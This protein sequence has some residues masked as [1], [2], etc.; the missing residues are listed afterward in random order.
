[1]NW[2]G[3]CL[4][5]ANGKVLRIN[6]DGTIPADNP[7]VG[8]QVPACDGSPG[9]QP[10]PSNVTGTP[11]TEIWSWGFRNPFRFSFDPQTGR[12]WLVDVGEVS[13]EEVDLVG[14]GQ[15]YGWPWRGGAF[16]YPGTVCD[17]LGA[18]GGGADRLGPRYLGEGRRGAGGGD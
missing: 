16:G 2:I 4:T 8:T 11:R 14:K 9:S 17:N 5:T 7:L 12:L 18:N 15:H 3:T 6:L 13:Y 1:T 10:D